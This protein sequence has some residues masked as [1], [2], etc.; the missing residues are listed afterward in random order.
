MLCIQCASSLGR[1]VSAGGLPGVEVRQSSLLLVGACDVLLCADYELLH[2]LIMNY[3]D[4]ESCLERK[5][6]GPG[7]L[8]AH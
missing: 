1:H 3:Y 8:E 5:L 4:Y 2:M 6:V 7:R